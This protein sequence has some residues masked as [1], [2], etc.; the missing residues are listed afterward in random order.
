[1]QSAFKRYEAV[2]KPMLQTLALLQEADPKSDSSSLI[3]LLLQQAEVARV[4]SFLS[5]ERLLT[6]STN[7]SIAGSIITVNSE[8]GLSFWR[9]WHGWQL[10]VW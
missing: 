6:G 3:K 2:A 8:Q 10:L 5:G 9:R 4:A 1:M 7:F